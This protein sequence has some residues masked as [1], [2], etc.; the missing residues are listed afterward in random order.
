MGLLIAV[1]TTSCLILLALPFA[2][3]I[4]LVAIM[5][6]LA[7]SAY[8][9][10]RDALLVLPASLQMLDVNAKGEL[11]VTNNRGETFQPKLAPSS[12]YHTK[13]VILNFQREGFNLAMPSL[14]LVENQQLD[15]KVADEIRRLRVYLRW[16]NQQKI[17]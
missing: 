6:I 9:T 5:V 13:M 8:Y 1:S 3:I 16:F 12:F 15:S 2:L 14:I 7:S 11:T 17:K 10:A 4:K